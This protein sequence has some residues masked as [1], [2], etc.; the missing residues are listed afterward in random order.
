[1]GGLAVLFLL[2][3]YLWIGFVIVRSYWRSKRRISAFVSLVVVVALPIADAL[4]GRAYL[5]SICSTPS[6]S[7]T[8]RTVKDVE[9]L[10]VHQH[11]FKGS[12]QYYGYLFVVG[13]DGSV[14]HNFPLESESTSPR[15]IPAVALYEL[16]TEPRRDSF[17]FYTVREVIRVRAN[18][19]ILATIEWPSFR[20]GWAER[21]AMAFSD[22]GPGTV[23]SCGSFNDQ[24]QQ[25][26]AWLHKTLVPKLATP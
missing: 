22:A 24:K 7:T 5:S 6:R 4:A 2:V 26:T 12:A 23:A 14:S 9:T 16:V 13:N 8:I 18:G 19:E 20:G 25:R 15:R 17:L 1:M 3:A 10:Y 21:I 11:V